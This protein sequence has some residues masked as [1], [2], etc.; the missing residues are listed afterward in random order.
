MKINADSVRNGKRG[1]R[2]SQTQEVTRA[3]ARTLFDGSEARGVG[4]RK[5]TR[6][7]LFLEMFLRLKV[8]RVPVRLTDS[9]VGVGVQTECA[10]WR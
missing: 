1:V 9:G 5:S 6:Q 7:L 2:E 3:R 4:A 10:G 8:R